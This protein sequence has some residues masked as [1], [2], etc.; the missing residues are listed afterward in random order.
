MRARR[1]HSLVEVVVAIALVSVIAT[2]AVTLFRA[3]TSETDESLAQRVLESA[4][5]AQ[6]SYRLNR[7]TF[8]VT[9]EAFANLA[10]GEATFTTAPSSDKSL[11][12]V[13]LLSDNSSLGLAVLVAQDKCAV[14]KV[15]TSGDSPLPRVIALNE[16]TPSCEPDLAN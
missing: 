13:G 3:A 6:E 5:A 8:A 9:P 15:T 7:G 12:S 16:V 4:A 11:V 14:L 10:A 2:I 1:G